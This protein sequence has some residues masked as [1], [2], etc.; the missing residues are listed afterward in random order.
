MLAAAR[1]TRAGAPPRRLPI[2]AGA[3]DGKLTVSIG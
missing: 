2:E 1:D 3:T